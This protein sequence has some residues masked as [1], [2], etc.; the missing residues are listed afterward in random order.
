MGVNMKDLKTMAESWLR[1]FLA[2]TLTLV[3]A[4][5]TDWHK[6]F[7]AGAAAVIPPILRY[8]NPNDDQLGIGKKA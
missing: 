8:I 2:A 1:A 3:L 6:L 4:G 5:E 7:Y